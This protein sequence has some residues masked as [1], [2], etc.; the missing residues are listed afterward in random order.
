MCRPFVT[1]KKLEQMLELQEAEIFISKVTKYTLEAFYQCFVPFLAVNG[2]TLVDTNIP[3]SSLKLEPALL[4]V[5]IESA[6][7]DLYR[8]SMIHNFTDAPSLPRKAAVVTAWLNRIKPIR[9]IDQNIK[10]EFI[11]LDPF[12]ALLVGYSIAWSEDYHKKYIENKIADFN[13]YNIVM[14]RIIE[15]CESQKLIIYHLLWHTPSFR[16]LSL[17]FKSNRTR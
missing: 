17:I 13:M 1:G 4:R 7:I 14:D 10:G 8:A 15:D 6:F 2:K 12:F 11:W 5:A 16:E 9:I 3:E